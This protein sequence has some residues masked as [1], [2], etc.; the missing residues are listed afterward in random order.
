MEGLANR[1][2]T[3]DLTSGH[4]VAG[5]F[6]PTLNHHRFAIR[7]RVQIARGRGR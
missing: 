3:F 1:L 7:Q 6:H 4:Q 2:Q 5:D